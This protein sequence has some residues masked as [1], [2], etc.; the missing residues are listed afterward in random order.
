[1]PQEWKDAWTRWL[2]RGEDYYRTITLPYLTS[3]VLEKYIP[4]YLR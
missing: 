1:M 2:P 4:P 3:G